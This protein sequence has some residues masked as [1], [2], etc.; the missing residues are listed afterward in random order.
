M[1]LFPDLFKPFGKLQTF[2]K[3]FKKQVYIFP[4]VDNYSMTNSI[5]IIPIHFPSIV[6]HDCQSHKQAETT[7]Q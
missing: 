4:K 7:H 6:H 3:V 2:Q 5:Q 1:L